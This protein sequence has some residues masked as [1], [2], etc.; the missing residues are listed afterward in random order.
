MYDTPSPTSPNG[1]NGSYGAIDGG[2]SN[3]AFVTFTGGIGECIPLEKSKASPDFFKIIKTAVDRGSLI[4]TSTTSDEGEAHGL[5]KGH[6]YSVTGIDEVNYKGERKELLQLRNPWGKSEWTGRWSDESLLWLDLDPGLQKT[7]QVKKDD[8][9]FW[10]EMNDFV[11]YFDDL[12]ICSLSPDSLFSDKTASWKVTAFHGRWISGYNA[13]GY[14]K[15]RENTF[16]NPQFHV[17]LREADEYDLKEQHPDPKCTLL[18]SLIQKDRRRGG[19]IHLPIGFQIYKI[20]TEYLELKHMSQ[21]RKM[22]AS[23]H[24]VDGSDYFE[25][26][27]NTKR[28]ELPPG[29]TS[30]FPAPILR[31]KNLSSSFG[32]SR[33]RRMPSI[34]YFNT[35]RFT[36]AVSA[37]EIDDEICADL[38]TLGM[39]TSVEIGEEV[40]N[41]FLQFAG[42]DQE[43]GFVELKKIL[44]V[45]L[46]REAGSKPERFQLETCRQMIR[47]F[48]YS[49]NGRLSLEEFKT[50]WERLREWKAIFTEHDRDKSGNMDAYEMCLALATA[51][52]HLNNQFCEIITN[53]YRNRGLCIDLNSFL[54]C[55][56]HL[57]WI[58]RQ[59]KTRDRDST[60]IVIM[61][62]KEWLELITAT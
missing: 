12:Q 21:R 15:K 27:V 19:K 57:T 50:L 54:S 51:G 30:S 34:S 31:I 20:P 26:E 42:Q 22:L 5:M 44:A 1:F 8:G 58:F 13:G 56:A 41:I 46:A 47:L 38:K 6:A 3:E 53:Q 29:D 23:F 10:M 62:H 45:T 36:V 59:C 40:E 33:R 16:K 43:I 2:F 49:K 17:R 48:D 39:G 7:L 11:K 60:G 25:E 32:F 9:E 35:C 24:Y 18:V 55:L 52:F 61:A 37:H 4:G 28:F 14:D